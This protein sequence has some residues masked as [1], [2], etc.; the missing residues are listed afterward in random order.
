MHHPPRLRKTTVPH[1]SLIMIDITTR[2]LK[3]YNSIDRRYP[4][5][6][7]AILKWWFDLRLKEHRVTENRSLWTISTPRSPTQTTGNTCG[8]HVLTVH[9]TLSTPGIHPFP[10][11]SSIMALKLW[12]YKRILES[13]A[14]TKEPHL[15][16]LSGV[17]HTREEGAEPN[18]HSN[19]PNARHP[20]NPKHSHHQQPP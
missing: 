8:P 14:H 13:P 2:K 9:H 1:W 11:P 18:T 7:D 6:Y 10:P 4:D 17:S 15:L 16:P 12:F 5:I 19:P 20:H 3:A